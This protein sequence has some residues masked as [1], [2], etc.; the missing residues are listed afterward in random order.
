M[1][2]ARGPR[3][4]LQVGTRCSSSST[5]GGNK[6][7][8]R[9]S[10][11]GNGGLARLRPVPATADKR[12]VT[13]DR[14]TESTVRRSSMA[15]VTGER[16]MTGRCP[17]GGRC[18]VKMGVGRGA[19]ACS[20]RGPRPVSYQNPQTPT[21]RKGSPASSSRMRR[22][23]TRCSTCGVRGR[24]WTYAPTRQC[25]RLPSHGKRCH[26]D[27]DSLQV[28]FGWVLIPMSDIRATPWQTTAN[29]YVWAKTRERG[30][31]SALLEWA[32]L[33][34]SASRSNES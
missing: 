5:H 22:R 33:E 28:R 29:I 19:L 7:A 4:G 14:S 18:Q 23:S 15:R 13:A 6:R 26:A 27:C 25:R 12:G 21:R 32:G 20:V 10:D 9:Y 34:P 30:P 8:P 1:L 31:A 16:K 2:D 24:A 3:G 17:A 11:R